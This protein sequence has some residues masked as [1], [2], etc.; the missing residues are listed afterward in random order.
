MAT[1]IKF[2][3]SFSVL[4]WASCVWALAAAL[5]VCPDRFCG[6]ALWVSFRSQSVV[7]NPLVVSIENENQEEVVISRIDTR[8][9]AEAQVPPQST[10]TVALGHIPT[11]GGF[12]T[13]PG[14]T[15][16][17]RGITASGRLVLCRGYGQEQFGVPGFKL[18]VGTETA[19]CG[20]SVAPYANVPR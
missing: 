5:L 3:A 18:Q 13:K 12:P 16:I 14:I 10:R 17:I 2:A 8:P 7:F 19:E 6:D 4:G 15:I 11:G 20:P 9:F 1:R